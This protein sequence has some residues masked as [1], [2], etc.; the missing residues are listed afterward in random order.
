M[1][2]NFYEIAFYEDIDERSAELNLGNDSFWGQKKSFSQPSGNAARKNS[3]KYYEFKLTSFI[4]SFY[5]K[6]GR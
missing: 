5:W 4:A 6:K 1:F 2:L 3:C